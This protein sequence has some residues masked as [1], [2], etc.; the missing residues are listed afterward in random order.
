MSK[1]KIENIENKESNNNYEINSWEDLDIK[2][3]LLRGI[4]SNGF[5]APSPIQ[6][7]AILP[8][9]KGNDVI[10][11]AQSGTG[12]TGCFSI[13]GLEIINTNENNIQL[14]ILSPTRELSHQTKNVIDRIGVNMKNL[15]SQLLVGDN[16]NN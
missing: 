15:R 3:D 11:Q 13:A 6:K 8:I 2:N 7:K 9:I 5:E 1:E 14:L 4:Y 12:K 16:I 10:A